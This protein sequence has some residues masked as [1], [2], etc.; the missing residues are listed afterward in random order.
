MIDAVA[1]HYKRNARRQ[2]KGRILNIRLT[3]CHK[4]NLFQLKTLGTYT[5]IIF[6]SADGKLL[7]HA[8]SFGSLGG[9]TWFNTLEHE[10]TGDIVGTT[11]GQISIDPECC[12]GGSCSRKRTDCNE[13]QHVSYRYSRVTSIHGRRTMDKAVIVKL[14][15]KRLKVFGVK[16][17]R[18]NRLGKGIGGMKYE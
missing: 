8:T 5:N 9:I 14:T 12:C 17:A 15:A 2:I 3:K 1:M 6:D 4:T 11:L 13:K 16:V 7:S 18:E 10:D